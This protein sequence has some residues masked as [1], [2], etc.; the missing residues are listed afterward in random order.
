MMVVEPGASVRDIGVQLYG[1]GLVRHPVIFRALV[2]V[3]GDQGRLRAG[4]YAIPGGLDLGQII[5]KLVRG[6]IVRH[7]VTF[8]EG[9]SLE[10]MAR[11]VAGQGVAPAAFL[12]AA[13]DAA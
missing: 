11:I 12:A 9:T 1:M 10:D 8:P 3:R 13:P 5:D 7:V 4:E 2:L 6:D